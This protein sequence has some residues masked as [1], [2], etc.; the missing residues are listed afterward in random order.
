MAQR[1][2]PRN[3]C[4]NCGAMVKR[5]CNIYCDNHCQQEHQYSKY[6]DDWLDGKELGFVGKTKSISKYIVRYLKEIRGDKCE[7]CGWNETNPTTHRVPVEIHHKDGDAEN[8][9]LENLLLLCPNHHSLTPT[10]RNLNKKS[11]RTR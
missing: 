11:K 6:I 10:F 9:R 7:I 1:K 4:L 2:K 8:T 3:R 5:A